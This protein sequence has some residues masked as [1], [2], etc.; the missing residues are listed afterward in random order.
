MNITPEKLQKL[1]S[2]NICIDIIDVRN[3][4]Q[5]KKNPLKSLKIKETN[6]EKINIS[7]LKNNSV[8][9]CQFGIE[10]E[11]FIIDKKLS[12]VYNLIGG[13][14]AWN[15]YISNRI[16]I[17]RYNRQM[18]LSQV[19]EKGQKKIMDSKVSIIGLG[20]LGTVVAQYL[21]GAGIG[22]IKLIDGDIISLTNLH[23]QP[24]YPISSIGHSKSETLRKILL[25]LNENCN[26]ISYNEYVNNEN[27]FE[28]LKDTQIIVDATDNI[29][30]R[31]I[32]DSFCKKSK[33]PLVYGGL[34]K[35]EGQVAVFNHNL[36]IS[37]SD[38]FS[39]NKINENCNDVGILG[40]IPSIIGNIQSLEVLKI[41]LNISPNL[42]GKLLIYDGLSHRIEK[43]ELI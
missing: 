13:A 36:E 42:S 11:R 8:L 21:V 40:M 35:F 23:R 7:D 2:E 38:I 1:I 39:N 10:T 31:L 34:Y 37:Y 12:N 30:S 20:G 18:V 27:I 6:F 24:I 16:D 26:L 29:D 22:T 41:I 32:I 15:Y 5:K 3:N 9:I 28:I 33:T 19:G 4:F 14:L 17:S 43:I 25:K